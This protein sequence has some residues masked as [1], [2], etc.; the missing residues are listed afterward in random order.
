M[1]RAAI[2]LTVESFEH[3]FGGQLGLD[4]DD[5]VREY[6]H[7]WA[8]DYC[9][10]LSAQGVEPLIYVPSV[11][12]EGLRP[13]PDGYAVRFV[14]LGRGYW[15]WVRLPVLKRSPVGR[16]GAFV[17]G[18][19]SMLGPLRRAL[20][21]DRADALFV[22]EYWTGRF[23][24]LARRL[25][26]PLI[27]VDQGMRDKR[28]VKLLKRRTLPRAA[29]VVTQTEAESEKVRR[30][31]G[32]PVQVPNGVDTERFAPD[33]AL[34]REPGLVLSA[35]RL[36]DTQKRQSDLIEA[37]ARLDKP[38]RLELV[39]TGPH[40]ARF[41]ELAERLGVADR[42]RFAGFVAD[43]DELRDRFRR[44]SVFALPSRF[45][46][47]PVAL[48]EAM[49]CGAPAV[50]TDIP[51]IAEVIEDGVNGR[52]VPLGDPVAL[53]RAIVAAGASGERYSKAA[54]ETIVRRFGAERM[55]AELARLLE[56]ATRRATA[57]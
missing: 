19:L 53:A 12:H 29:A 4:A 15:P 5:Y 35:G 2:L 52:L 25:E 26:T 33:P 40:E 46:G 20:A 24:V 45:E 23:D 30:Y 41:R 37:I 14:P 57:L 28:E 8:W 48:I 22:Q 11:E 42:V 54:R 9:A 51:A 16:Y 31:G 34:E 47:L 43:R 55:G 17:A 36:E 32:R 3:F 10:A 1:S 27:A 18:A 44:C 38:W 7:D 13:T 39:G 6:R 21:E 49:S 50:G 56:D